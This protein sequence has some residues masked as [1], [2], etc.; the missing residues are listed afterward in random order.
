MRSVGL[1]QV[2]LAANGANL[3]V[4]RGANLV[5]YHRATTNRGNEYRVGV[6]EEPGIRDTIAGTV[7]SG[8]KAFQPGLHKYG[9]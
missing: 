4:N 9:F 8:E 5:V 1:C 7:E 3:V 6:I 2:I